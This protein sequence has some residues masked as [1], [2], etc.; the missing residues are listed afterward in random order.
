MIM[1]GVCVVLRVCS[2]KSFARKEKIRECFTNLVEFFDDEELVASAER[3]AH[4]QERMSNFLQLDSVIAPRCCPDHNLLLSLRMRDAIS[5]RSD[6]N[7]KDAL[8]SQ[9]VLRPKDE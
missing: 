1:E 7:Y 8:V 3:T 5:V 4:S 9:W 2:L 6:Y